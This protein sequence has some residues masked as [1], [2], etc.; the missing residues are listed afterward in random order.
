MSD[1]TMKWLQHLIDQN[2]LIEVRSI[3]LGGS[4][5]SFILTA[6]PEEAWD[7]AENN[8]GAG[9]LVTTNLNQRDPSEDGITTNSKI[10]VINH[11]V[12]DFDPKRPRGTNAT[13]SEVEAA[14]KAAEHC[15][16][17][18]RSM[19][20]CEPAVAFTGSGYH[21]LYRTHFMKPEDP[22]GYGLMRSL[23]QHMATHFS[24]PQV[25]FDRTVRNPG[26][27][28]RLYGLPNLKC[29]SSPD[30]PQRRTWIEM[31]ASFEIT[32][33]DIISSTVAQLMPS[34]VIP[35]PKQ[36]VTRTGS[37]SRRG[38]KDIRT[39]DIVAWAQACGLYKHH[40]EEHKHSITCPWSHEHSEERPYA[41]STIVYESQ[42]GSWPG[43]F[44]HHAS[45][46]GRGIKDLMRDFP[47]W[48]D[49]A[50][51]EGQSHG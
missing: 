2:L 34:N 28:V 20:W 42:A 7:W 50:D 46:E 11:L 35:F 19:G 16:E 36:K 1:S 45:C 12:F 13:D 10:E 18:M 31:P 27:M 47:D 49:W 51:S 25:G 9:R 30:R 17:S 43:I 39:F 14:A 6:D 29:P 41:N 48:K 44:C 33:V 3:H 21:L 24:T 37:Q 26:R 38:L 40:I 23:Y 4:G 5:T 8:S 15:L 32:D 22:E